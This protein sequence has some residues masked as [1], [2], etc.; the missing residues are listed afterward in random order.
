MIFI[1]N[2]ILY[3]HYQNVVGFVELKNVEGRTRVKIKHNV[4][5]KTDNIIATVNNNIVGDEITPPINLED[6]IVVCLIQ[7]D[8]SKV[9]T[10][11]SGILNPRATVLP[12][13][14][15]QMQI[16]A[17]PHALN[18]ITEQISPLRAILDATENTPID[19]TVIAKP[20]A[21]HEID[22]ILRAVCTIG[23]DKKGVCVTCPYRDYFFG[24]NIDISV[25]V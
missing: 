4:Q 16:E 2:V 20:T 7:K 23:G 8:N 13:V 11:A 17:E 22:E 24:E 6:E 21:K 5:T 3:D 9:T 15:A 25:N 18:S 19:R 1:K 10:L 12:A 14:G